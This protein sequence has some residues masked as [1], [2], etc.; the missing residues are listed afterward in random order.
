MWCRMY[1]RFAQWR[2]HAPF[3]RPR[4]IGRY[5]ANQGD[6][7]GNREKSMPLLSMRRDVGAVS[8][9]KDEEVGG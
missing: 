4:G 1:P 9:G 5:I 8:E 7:T 6:S 2:D 3:K